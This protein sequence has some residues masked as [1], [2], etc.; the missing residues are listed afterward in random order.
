VAKL[1]EA[2]LNNRRLRKAD[3][4]TEFVDAA[5]SEL[6][7][8]DEDEVED[9]ARNLFSY[10]EKWRL[11]VLVGDPRNGLTF[12][13]WISRAKVTD[14]PTGDVISDTKWLAENGLLP[15]LEECQAAAGLRL[16]AARL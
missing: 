3:S 12:K 8:S 5:I 6:D 9:A 7:I 13:D 2:A 10:F 11:E 15:D 4:E 16:G 14:D 1:I